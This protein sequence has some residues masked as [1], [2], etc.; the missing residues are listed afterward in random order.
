MANN[1]KKKTNNLKKE[2]NKELKSTKKTD[3]K[4][5]K[6]KITKRKSYADE[7]K[8]DMSL[9]TKTTI[10]TIITVIMVLVTFYIIS[11]Y[12]TGGKIFNFKKDSNEDVQ[13]QY[14]EIL[15]GR[16]FD[17]GGNYFVIYFDKTDSENEQTI[18]LTNL[19]TDFQ[20]NSSG[21]SI[22]TCDLGNVFN[23][24][25]VTTEEPNTNPYGAED[26]LLNGPT[27]I[28]FSDGKVAEYVY[29]YENVTNYIN[30]YSTEAE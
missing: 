8:V 5:V 12:A 18:E 2:D 25:F 3:K 28:R 6:K 15:L 11:I 26:M 16:S 9:Q 10:W 20:T 14:S 13:I 22:Y 23:K 21:A 17:M 1:T 19:V 30:G 7:M 24:P 29:G 27:L 4:N